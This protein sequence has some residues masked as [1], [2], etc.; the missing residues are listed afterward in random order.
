MR[1]KICR[2]I[3]FKLPRCLVAQCGYRI[4]ANATTGKHSGQIVSELV[5]MEAMRRWE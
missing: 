1:E 5:F 4:G 2:W 3:A